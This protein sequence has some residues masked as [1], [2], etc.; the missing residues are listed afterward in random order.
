MGGVG[1]G[2]KV[3]ISNPLPNQMA[4]MQEARSKGM[5]LSEAEKAWHEMV[6]KT[7]KVEGGFIVDT[8]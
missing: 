5:G 1:E 6:S 2:I 4:F 7:I 3:P 8:A